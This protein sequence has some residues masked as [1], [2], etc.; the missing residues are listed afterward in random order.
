MAVFLSNYVITRLECWNTH[1]TDGGM[2][3]INYAPKT[4]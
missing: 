4:Y 3:E 2:R 1:L